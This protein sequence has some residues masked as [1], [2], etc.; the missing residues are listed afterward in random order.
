MNC[1]IENECI[2]YFSWPTYC[3][4]NCLIENE[5]IC[6]FFLTYMLLNELP[7]WKRIYTWFFFLIYWWMNCLIENEYIRYFLI[8]P[9][10]CRMTCLVESGYIIRKKRILTLDPWDPN[11]LFRGKTPIIFNYMID[12]LISFSWANYIFPNELPNWKRIDNEKKK[13]LFSDLYIPQWIASLKAEIYSGKNRNVLFSNLYISQR[14]ARLKA[15]IYSEKKNQTHILPNDL[16][17][18][19]RIF[20]QKKSDLY[21]A[22]WLA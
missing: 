21:I 12:W 5:Y 14:I 22:E 8:W 3:W 11:T 1:L 17:N 9:I 7:N 18:W 6:D 15:N 10:Y 19:Q 13:V 20:N 16:P 2:R 4:M